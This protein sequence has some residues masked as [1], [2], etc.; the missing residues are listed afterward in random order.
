M[1]I[2][3]TLPNL[4][5]LLYV[6]SAGNELPKRKAGGIRGL[7]AGRVGTPA[8]SRTNSADSMAGPG[9]MARRA[10][11][12]GA[13]EEGRKRRGEDVQLPFRGL[14]HTQSLRTSGLRENVKS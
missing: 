3:Q 5:Y 12:N 4:K 10:L 13:A 8:Q 11:E 1:D 6:C 7:L 2:R 9:E 14:T